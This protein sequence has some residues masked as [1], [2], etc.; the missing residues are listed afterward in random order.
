MMM[1]NKIALVFPGQGCQF[2]GMGREIHD[3]CAQIRTL[4]AQADDILGVR[5]SD[6]CFSGPDEV[7]GDTANTQPAV[8]LVTM[9]LWQLLAPKLESIRS[10]LAYVA[11]HSLGEYSALAASGAISFADG[12]RLVRRRG[13]AM[14]DAGA[15]AP[16]GM[17]VIIGLDDDTVHEIVQAAGVGV[18]V[19]NLN[20]PGQVVIAGQ[21]EPLQRALAL[22]KEYKARRALALAVSVACHTP[23][24]SG[25]SDRLAAA[26]SDTPFAEPWV[27]VV[28]NVEAT[29][30]SAPEQIRTALIKQLSSPV[31]WVESVQMM[32]QAGVTATI[33][34][35]PKS[36]VTGLVRRIDRGIKTHSVTDLQDLDA[37]DAEAI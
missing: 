20:S 32:A 19:A 22:A 15:E 2:V 23:L 21:D 1:D 10:R 36:V 4:F 25:A 26:L 27:P 31:R 33:E 9:A 18:W 35:G 12:L 6:I 30:F 16:G 24:M 14:R 11:G 3:N 34:I 5:L 17:A 29:P 13:E 8:Y 28:S 7:L 37:F